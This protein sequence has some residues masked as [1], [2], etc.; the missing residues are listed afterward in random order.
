MVISDQAIAA[1][2]KNNRIIGRLMMAFDMGQNTIENWMKNKDVRLT[3]PTAVE[4]IREET[5]LKEEEILVA[6]SANAASA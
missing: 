6:V 3:T 4:I 5:G 1:I 2:K